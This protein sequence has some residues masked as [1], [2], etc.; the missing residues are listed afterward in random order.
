MKR[1]FKTGTIFLAITLATLTIVGGANANDKE[2]EKAK[3]AGA[4][5]TLQG[6]NDEKGTVTLL[7]QGKSEPILL[8]V[9]PTTV[10]GGV[11]HD[12]HLF[13][14][15]KAS[16]PAKICDTC[17]CDKTNVECIAWKPVKPKTWQAMLRALPPGIALRVIYH[18]ANK[19]ETGLKTLTVD[20]RTV[21]LPVEGLGN[22]TAD[23]L[24]DLVK[25]IGGINAEMLGGGKQL[26]IDLK[27]DWTLEREARL[28]KALTDAGAKVTFKYS[29]S[30]RN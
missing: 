8:Q 4:V 1:I 7:P 20:H 6:I 5:T 3:T 10:L 26:L 27:E 15:F 19:P 17:L 28:E 23:Q 12:C 14:V 9:S 22:K 25:P 11:C 29:N 21:L 30:S 18:E 2:N 24:L 16:E 13:Q